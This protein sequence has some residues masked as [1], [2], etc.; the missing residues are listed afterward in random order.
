MS[1]LNIIIFLISSIT[2]KYRIFVWNKGWGKTE[3]KIN[4]KNV[5]EVFMF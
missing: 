3:C 1:V 4:T 5:F 2:L